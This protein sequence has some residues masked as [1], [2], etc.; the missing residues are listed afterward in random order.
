VNRKFFPT[1]AQR[2]ALSLIKSSAKHIL[3]FGGARSGKTTI[4]V[5]ALIFRSLR[6]PGSRHLICRLRLKDARS[7][8][9]HETM[10]PWLDRII[11]SKLYKLNRHNNYIRLYN[12]S[13]IW[14]GGLG[15]KEQVDRILGHKIFMYLY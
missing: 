2:E 10:N 11:G 4:V 13:E 6:Y 5:L 14:I 8:V 9:L 15:D 12:G 7:S 3:L 1:A